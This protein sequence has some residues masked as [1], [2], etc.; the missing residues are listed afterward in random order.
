MCLLYG[1]FA[2]YLR[3]VLCKRRLIFPRI[4]GLNVSLHSRSFPL[5]TDWRKSDISVDGEP[6]GN[7][8]RNSN[9]GDEVASSSSFSRLAARAPRRTCSQATSVYIY[10]I[11]S[12][13]DHIYKVQFSKPPKNIHTF[14]SADQLS[15]ISNAYRHDS[16]RPWR[17][18]HVKNKHVACCCSPS[19][20]MN[21]W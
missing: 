14:F 9:S 18:L 20:L 3:R 6:Q 12:S 4:N 8:R 7:W 11:F 1:K 17:N 16:E 19:N 13:R 15:F 2:S 21:N 10:A 5:R